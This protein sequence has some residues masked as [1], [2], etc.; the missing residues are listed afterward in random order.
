MEKIMKMFNKTLVAGAILAFAAFG[1]ASA[2]ELKFENKVETDT[3]YIGNL[4]LDDTPLDYYNDYRRFPGIHETMKMEYTSERVDAKVELS[5]GLFGQNG[6]KWNTTEYKKV[7]WLYLDG[8][9]FGEVYIKFRPIEILQ[10]D[11]NTREKASGSYFPVLDANVNLGNYTGDFGLLVKPIDGLSIGAGI[12]FL[13][14]LIND[15]DND[16]D[17]IY[18]NFGAEYELENIGSFAL[19]FNNVLN[20]FG[21]GAFAK[22]NAINALDIYGG[23]SYQNE[24]ANLTLK[25]LTPHYYLRNYTYYGP[26]VYDYSVGTYSA[27]IFLVNGNIILNA[28]AEYKGIDKLTL[29]AELATNCFTGADNTFDLYTGLKAEYEINDAFSVSGTSYMSFDF[30]DSRNDSDYNCCFSPLISFYPEVAYKLGN[31]TFKAGFKMEF[32]QSYEILKD[33]DR[34]TQFTAAIPLSWTYAF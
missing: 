18:L 26:G 27:D 34:K 8:F 11:L 19:T 1:S 22:I 24:H 31:N 3:V 12:D 13:S 20:E 7:T 5:F 25:P 16:P 29:A 2:D 32:W 28:A 17:K 33:T 23:F 4:G 30:A 21:F 9:D 14:Y 6:D 10:I 15:Y